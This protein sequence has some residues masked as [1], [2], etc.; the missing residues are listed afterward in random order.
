MFDSADIARCKTCN[1]PLNKETDPLSADCGGDCWGCIGM[2][3][4]EL[5]QPESIEA[6]RKE[7]AAGLREANGTA[8]AFA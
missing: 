3:E 6:V 2:F 7:I 5:G 8:K 1:R 4:A